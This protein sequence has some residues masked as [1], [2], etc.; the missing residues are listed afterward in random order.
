MVDP[1]AAT[2]AL[3]LTGA[4]DMPGWR[5]MGRKRGKRAPHIFIPNTCPCTQCLYTRLCTN[6]KAH[7]GRWN[8]HPK[9][10]LKN[11]KTVSILGYLNPH[12][13]GTATSLR[14]R[15]TTSS[16]SLSPE[17][18]PRREHHRGFSHPWCRRN[19]RTL[20][21]AKGTVSFN[22]RRKC[23][24]TPCFA[25]RLLFGSYAVFYEFFP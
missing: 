15:S 2:R 8:P 7:L 12:H 25:R 14:T 16:L 22:R 5:W 20:Y 10:I 19:T 17:L 9:K 3:L 23:S 11:R 24:R 21:P 4:R 1:F 13:H 6:L 18:L